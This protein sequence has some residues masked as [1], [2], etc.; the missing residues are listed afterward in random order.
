[1]SDLNKLKELARN[2]FEERCA[3]H[4]GV[5]VSM[6][7]NWRNEKGA[8]HTYSQE[9]IDDMWLGFCLGV[10]ALEKQQEITRRLAE[11]SNRL[12]EERKSLSERL[13][14]AQQRIAELERDNQMILAGAEWM[15]H[16]TEGWVSLLKRTDAA[17]AEINRRDAAAGE[18]YGYVHK[19]VYE[20][21][22]SAGLSSDSERADCPSYIPLYTASQPSALPPEYALTVDFND[23]H[24]GWNSCLNAAKAL[25]V[26]PP[27]VDDLSMQIR[28]LV[29]A[30]KNSKPDHSLVKSVPDYMR[31]K[32]YWK[33]TDCLRGAEGIEV[34]E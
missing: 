11:E 24:L 23:Y 15:E 25:G 27:E 3:A 33:V 12:F 5:S 18:P 32:G 13:E 14:A 22:G 31:R 8:Q 28:R 4:E 20:M 1:M 6:I 2:N 10:D 7:S 17:E 16:L 34:E 29:H 19:G 26:K 9:K 21:A 30:L